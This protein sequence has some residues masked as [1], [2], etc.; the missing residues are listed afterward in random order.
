MLHPGELTAPPLRMGW[1]TDTDQPLKAGVP[2]T[3]SDGR[4]YLRLEICENLLRAD[5]SWR[6]HATSSSRGAAAG[7]IGRGRLPAWR[8]SSSSES[9]EQIG[10]TGGKPLAFEVVL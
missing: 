8:A 3:D 10:V 2:A 9:P 5:G 6:D 4:R 7:A 1:S